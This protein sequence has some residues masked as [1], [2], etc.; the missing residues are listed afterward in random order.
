[1]KTH[2]GKT[3]QLIMTMALVILA[4]TSLTVAAGQQRISEGLPLPWPFP[5]AKECPIDWKSIDGRY[6][7]SDSARDERIEISTWLIQA[8]NLHVIRVQ[9]F[10]DQSELLAQGF[11]V[12]TESQRTIS[13]ELISVDGSQEHNAEASV[14]FYYRSDE[15]M[16]TAER[17]VP[18][19]QLKRVEAGSIIQTTYR[20]IPMC[21]RHQ[22]G[23]NN[24]SECI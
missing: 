20:L 14:R 13:L 7:M 2:L 1:M 23:I 9:K 11:A 12:I 19:L 18:L 24:K 8:W 22:I 6:S 16:C 5:W 21:D 4:S 15:L 17:L 10:S 3:S